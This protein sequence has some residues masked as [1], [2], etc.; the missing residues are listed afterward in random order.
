MMQRFMVHLD[1]T[2]EPDSRVSPR[3]VHAVKARSRGERVNLAL[4]TESG[5]DDRLSFK[6]YHSAR[7]A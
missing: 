1:S 7:L 3:K 5:F 6:R 2:A 4:F